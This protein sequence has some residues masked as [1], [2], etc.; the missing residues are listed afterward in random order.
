MS[1]AKPYV[2]EQPEKPNYKD[3]KGTLLYLFLIPLFLAVVLAL[4]QTNI[5]AFLLST[6]SFF[7]FLAV[8]K[9]AKKGFT[10]EALYHT[11]TFTKA[12]KFPYKMYAGYLLGG[13]TFFTSF[14][15]GEQPLLK[16]VFLAFIATVGYYL[17]YGFDPKKDKLENLG[18]VSAEFV[19]ETIK[20]AKTKLSRVEEDMLHIKDTIL[21]SKLQTA[22][23]QA[24]HILKTI[25]ED[26][27][28]VR[29]ARKFLTVYIDGIAKVTKSYTELD[30]A[31]ITTETTHR[32]H[33][34]MDDVETRLGKELSRLKNNNAFDLDVHIDVLKEQIKG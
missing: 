25:Q 4:F 14:I 10:Q 22:L 13:A 29:V 33:T 6:V 34:L 5:K 9:L 24:D 30:E 12:P 3:I 11:N 8:S 20:E 16:S 26:P 17:L 32:L 18:D 7:L 27:K 31:D 19:L 21:H 23:T 2:A 28:D 1:K 15:T